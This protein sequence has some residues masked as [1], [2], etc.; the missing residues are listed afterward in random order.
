[1]VHMVHTS[2]YSL[3]PCI[4]SLIMTFSRFCTQ[5]RLEMMIYHETIGGC[6]NPN[7]NIFTGQHLVATRKVQEL[8]PKCYQ[9]VVA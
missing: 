1:M 8:L 9:M 6:G 7:I 2:I 3:T 5:G 4:L